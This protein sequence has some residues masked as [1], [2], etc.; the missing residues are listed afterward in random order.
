MSSYKTYSEYLRHP[1]F[2]AVVQKCIE[3]SNGRCEAEID[4]HDDGPV[5]CNK[6]APLEPHHVVYPEWGQFD[7][8]EN[9]QMICRECHENAHRCVVC[10][11]V[12]L[13]ARHIKH[14]QNWCCVRPW[15]WRPIS[16][17]EYQ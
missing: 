13:K 8:P 7:V 12:T 11:E 17:K 16:R 10:R 4:W 14:G 2:R 9:I 1:K 6:E 3:R 5:L 15:W